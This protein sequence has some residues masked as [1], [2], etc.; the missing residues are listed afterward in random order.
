MGDASRCNFGES[1]EFSYIGPSRFLL[2]IRL[3][4]FAV[5]AIF[6]LSSSINSVS[7]LRSRK[8]STIGLQNVSKSEIAK[9]VVIP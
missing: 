1:N 7:R 9:D 5:G 8:N 2:T 4:A 3:G 6:T